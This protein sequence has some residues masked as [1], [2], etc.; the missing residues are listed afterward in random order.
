MKRPPNGFGT[1][2][3]KAPNSAKTE[4]RKLLRTIKSKNNAAK[5][6]LQEIR[7][8]GENREKPKDNSGSGQASHASSCAIGKE[9]SAA[10]HQSD[11]IR[12]YTG[13]QKG[14]Q[15]RDH[16]LGLGNVSHVHREEWLASCVDPDIIDLNVKSLSG[17]SPYDYLCYS[18]DLPRLNTGALSRFW[19]KRYVHTYKGG[20]WCNGIDVLTG[21]DSLWGCFK[22]DEKH[23]DGEGK[24]VKYEHPPKIATEIFALK[25]PHRLWELIARRYDVALPENYQELPHSAFWQWVINNPQIPVIIT[26]GAKKAGAVLSCGYVCIAVPGINSAY[27]QPKDEFGESQGF[28]ALI[29]HLQILAQKGRRIYFCYDEDLKR[30]TTKAVKNAITKTGKLFSFQGCEV[31]VIS[32]H[33]TMGKG[34]DDILAS[35]GRETFDELYR[36]A[37]SFDDW[38]SKQLRQLSYTP[39]LT[40]NQ[41]YIGEIVPPPSAQLIGARA[42]K[43]SGKT[44]WLKFLSDPRLR[45]GEGRVLLIT[46]R[47]QLSLQGAERLG[48]PYITDLRSTEQGSLFGYGCCIDSIHPESQAHFNP[49]EWRGAW[50]IID[51]AM[52]VIWHLLTSPTCAQKRVV[53]IKTLQELLR[54]VVTTGGK[55]FI[56]DADLSDVGIDFIEGLLGFSPERFLLVNDYK[57]NEPWTIHRFGGK[58]PAKLIGLLEKRIKAGEKALLSVSGQRTKSTWGTQVAEEH[59]RRKFPDLKILRIDSETVSNPEHPAYRS[60]KNINEIVPLYDLVIASPTIETGISID[61]PHFDGVWFIGQGVQTCDGVRQNLSRVRPPVPRYVWIRPQGISFVGNKGT[62]P[63]ALIAGQ[64]NVDK[65]HR[66]KLLESGLEMPDGNFLPICLQTWAKKASVINMGMYFYER[67]ILD[68]LKQEGHIVVDWDGNEEIAPDSVK[69]EVT[70][71]RD[72]LYSKYQNDVAEANKL[73][74][75]EFEK[76]SKQ[77]ERRTNELLELRKAGIERK[78][79]IDCTPGLV[80]KDDD[81]WGTKLR[82]HYYWKD[83]REYLSFRDQ[84][85]FEKSIVHGQ[86]DY[87]VPD[88]NKSLLQLRVALLDYLGISQLYE[89]HGFHNDH[90]VVS[91][92]F[93]KIKTNVRHIQSVAGVDLRQQVRDGKH[94]IAAIQHILQMLGHRMIN[95]ARKGTRGKQIRYYSV[96]ASGFKKN[97][98]T[99]KPL[100][101]DR[102]LPI[103]ESDGREPVFEAWL[104]RDFEAKRKWEEEK[105][106]AQKQAEEALE[107]A[108][109]GEAAREAREAREREQF[110]GLVEMLE[111]CENRE[112]LNDIRSISIYSRDLLKAAA[113]QVSTEQRDRIRQWVTVVS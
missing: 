61:V 113:K 44:Q 56:M 20:W 53:I 85:I 71:V 96:P 14:T 48:L 103:P 90:P 5:D 42:P 97:E 69:E 16:A 107:I 63:N 21:K 32:W 64:R 81:K 80:K 77:Q 54:T 109:R 66:A 36:N 91:E 99:K 76:L 45:S 13:G 18:E 7:G 83:G 34:I 33:P 101:D 27:R 28:A 68:D 88:N 108:R 50:V 111:A 92:I 38:Q 70:S 37:A 49:N 87:F 75:T 84:Q 74:N 10:N 8:I 94:K 72:E 4:L 1:P 26:E 110:L 65:A 17:N 43:G 19:M 2:K 79:L 82:L 55:I 6:T 95:Y 47:I 23:I 102:G 35:L 30:T 29:P 60:T 86:G 112:M 22:S 40:I 73:T 12:N 15:A 41:R 3:L 11:A 67:T 98:E 31:N 104:Q 25:I 105:L 62:T 93:D 78:Y 24:S 58:N 52:Q 106:Q 59:F 100:L 51:E 89:D 46:H 39:D 57:F 9:Q